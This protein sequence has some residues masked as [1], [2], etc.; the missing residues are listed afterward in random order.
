MKTIV[1][2]IQGFLS[3]L[4]IYFAAALLVM[5]VGKPDPP[6]EV[7][8]VGALIGG[9]VLSAYILRR[10]ARS[11]SKVFSRGFLLG[12]AEWLAMIPVG[13]IYAGKTASSV[14]SSAPTE[15]AGAAAAGAA[16]GGGIMTIITGGVAV[17]FAVLCMLGFAV[18]HFIGREMKR[19]TVPAMKVCPACAES[20]RL[21]AVKC[22][23]CGADV[24]ATPMA[25]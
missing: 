24:G 18:S 19:E 8:M 7:L 3:G 14:V 10:G 21:E 5:D 9:W 22:R 20:I 11:V 17:A 1:A 25:R 6:S 12:A 16:L 4:M 2:I 15:A 23:Y 13:M